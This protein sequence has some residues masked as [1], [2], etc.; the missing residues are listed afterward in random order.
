MNSIC[1]SQ[2]Q[3]LRSRY[4]IAL[5]LQYCSAIAP[6]HDLSPARRELNESPSFYRTRINQTFT[7]RQYSPYAAKNCL[8]RSNYHSSAF[9]NGQ[10]PE[11]D[12]AKFAIAENAES[13]SH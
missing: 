1:L 7:L 13:A 6:N 3:S 8:R 12:V 11:A 5:A 10:L 9:M 2:P 4:L